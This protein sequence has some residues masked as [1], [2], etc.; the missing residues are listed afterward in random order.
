M[1]APSTSL[2]RTVK[3]NNDDLSAAILAARGNRSQ[4]STIYDINGLTPKPRKQAEPQREDTSMARNQSNAWQAIRSLKGIGNKL[5]SDPAVIRI[6][7]ILAEGESPQALAKNS[8][9]DILVATNKRI[10][11]IGKDWWTHKERVISYPY[12]DIRT[13]RAALGFFEP[14]L[15]MTMTSG[16]VKLLA[17]DKQFRQRFAEVVRSYLPAHRTVGKLPTDS[18]VRKME[19][20]STGPQR[21]SPPPAMQPEAPIEGD[22]RAEVDYAFGSMYAQERLLV[23]ITKMLVVAGITTENNVQELIR[24]LQTVPSGNRAF[25]IGYSETFD[26]MAKDLTGID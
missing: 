25:N 9:R 7:E 5:L 20:E 19:N 23:H 18:E 10:I 12:D 1:S 8:S 24:Q 17:A 11:V 26:K 14:G 4:D 15:S 22:I 16:G 6:P 13:F 2:A 21:T 3:W